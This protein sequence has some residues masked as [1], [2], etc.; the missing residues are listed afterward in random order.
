M[1]L[2]SIL[3]RGLYKSA[4]ILGDVSALKNGT[5]LKRIRNRISGKIT[6]KVLKKINS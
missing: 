2:I 6:G 3:R 5:V 4:K 1:G